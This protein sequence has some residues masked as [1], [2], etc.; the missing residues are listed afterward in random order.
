MDSYHACSKGYSSAAYFGWRKKSDLRE[1]V[2]K[3]LK[4]QGLRCNC[5][6]C[7][8]VGHR[9]AVD[10]FKPDLEKIEILTQHY[11]ASEGTEVFISAE[12]PEE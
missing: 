2:Q 11:K 9:W 3:R 7:R 5:I 6:R 10:R 12:D 8:E 1:L 4:A